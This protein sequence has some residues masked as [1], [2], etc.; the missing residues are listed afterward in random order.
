M[1]NDLTNKFLKLLPYWHY[2][3]ERQIKQK[4]DK[5]ISFESYYCLL[6]L[7]KEKSLTMTQIANDFYLGKQQAT[8]IIDTLVSYGL[9]E[10]KINESDKR[11]TDVSI[12]EK[13]VVFLN[14]NP[15]DTTDLKKD[16]ESV[17]SQSELKELNQ[18]L[19]TLIRVFMKL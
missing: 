4:N 19:D 10:K 14:E 13:G 11:R 3:V 5:N 18:A 17:C 6:G 16:I 8:R 15:F 2:N 1:T 12:S 7:A 9:V